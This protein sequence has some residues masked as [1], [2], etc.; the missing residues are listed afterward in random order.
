M[1]FINTIINW[2]FATGAAALI[3]TVLPGF[4]TTGP[5]KT[6]QAAALVGLSSLVYYMASIAS[7]LGRL[8]FSETLILDMILFLL[9]EGII[10]W[11]FLITLYALFLVL[12]K[13]VLNGFTT[14]EWWWYPV[15]GTGI[16]V[17]VKVLQFI[18]TRFLYYNILQLL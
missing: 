18:Y 6:F 2:L 4:T 5:K 7:L 13:R 8:F 15:G 11:L 14:K 17:I 1:I 9:Y 12:A 3:I 16:T 10:S